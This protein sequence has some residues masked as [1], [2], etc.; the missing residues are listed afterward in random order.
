MHLF[1]PSTNY[2]NK[3]G[4]DHVR[5]EWHFSAQAKYT[6]SFFVM[7]TR[8]CRGNSIMETV[9]RKVPVLVFVLAIPGL[10]WAQT[11]APIANAGSNQTAVV[12][13]TIQLDGSASYDPQGYPIVGWA[14]DLVSMPTGA[15][16]PLTSPNTK[17]TGFDA[18]IVGDYVIGLA[19]WNGVYWSADSLVAITVVPVPPPVAVINATP[20]SGPAPLTVQF[21]GSQ[22]YDPMG[23][24]LQY[25][26]N[27]G[28]G[29]ISTAGPTGSH[30]YTFADSFV[31][32]LTVVSSSGM[33]DNATIQITVKASA[34]TLYISRSSN[35]VTVY[36]QAVS[37]WSLQQNANIATTNWTTCSG[38]TNTDGVNYLNLV[39]PTGY[40]FFRLH[41]F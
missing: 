36:W 11:D 38:V 35:T 19:V 31:A 17:I 18:C 39:N 21:D 20:T 2:E 12:G 40:L 1:K 32:M 3:T 6:T 29:S 14:W 5:A 27:F 26:W 10:A 41:S 8:V 30:T 13:Y 22:S 15:S 34:P 16:N 9:M 24:T 25:G 33:N 7:V 28:D 37:G 4:D 23:G